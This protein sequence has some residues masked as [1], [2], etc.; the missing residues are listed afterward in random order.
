VCPCAGGPAAAAWEPA[1][2]NLGHALRKLRRWGDA[3]G[4]LRRALAL[5]PWAPGTHAALG[6]TLHLQGRTAEAVEW[7]HTALG[8]RPED[9]FTAT[10]L[11][12]ALFEETEAVAGALATERDTTGREWDTPC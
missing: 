12:A 11:Q 10:M 7:Y 6:Y 9:V 4:C 2:V 3:E 1:W 8:L 5:A